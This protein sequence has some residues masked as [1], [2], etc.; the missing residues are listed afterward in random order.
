[1]LWRLVTSMDCSSGHDEDNGLSLRIK[2]CF[3]NGLY[4]LKVYFFKF[5]ISVMVAICFK[6]I[7]AEAYQISP[8][9]ILGSTS[10]QYKDLNVLYLN[11][12][13]LFGIQI[14]VSFFFYY[15]NEHF[16]SIPNIN[17]QIFCRG[18]PYNLRSH[19]IESQ[20]QGCL[21]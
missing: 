7:L 14:S 8:Y 15:Y 2:S 16:S 3:S 13:L 5:K 19:L 10:P 12:F 20:R 6:M 18:S 1:M 9:C 17:T 11:I 4:D 21:V